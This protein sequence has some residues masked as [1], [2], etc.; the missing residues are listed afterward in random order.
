MAK[1]PLPGGPGRMKLQIS[2]AKILRNSK[3]QPSKLASSEGG[4]GDRTLSFPW[5]LDFEF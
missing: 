3:A 2:N 5:I 4:I 1:P